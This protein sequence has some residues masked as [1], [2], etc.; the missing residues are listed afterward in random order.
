M[1]SFANCKINLGL[2]II[3]KRPDGYHNIETLFFP[4]HQA[5]LLEVTIPG[6]ELS[7]GH[8]YI[9]KQTGL[10]VDC[11]PEK[12][13]LVKA[14]YALKAV[15]DIPCVYMHLHKQVPMGAGLGGGS[16]DAAALVKTLNNILSLGLSNEEME[17]ILSKVGA[18]C[19]FFV[20]NTPALASGIGDILT[21]IEVNTLKGKYIRLI[22]PEIHVSTAEA[23]AGVTPSEP[24]IHIEEIIKRPISEWMG[25]LVNDFEKSVFKAHPQLADI[26][27]WL[28]DKG[29]IY[30]AMS[31]SGST[32]FGIFD[33]PFYDECDIIE[34]AQWTESIE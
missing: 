1:I 3:N 24:Q 30:A 11:P 33:H 31:G 14:L 7:K 17:K 8:D 10:V 6:E 29:A 16:A 22:K 20:K 2:N 4:L 27:N 13:I 9:L 25:L 28:L 21:P 5:D 18:D 19:P 23:Y 34:A 15:R 12:N 26:K 32:I